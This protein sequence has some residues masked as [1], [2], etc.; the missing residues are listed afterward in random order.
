M[1]IAPKSDNVELTPNRNQPKPATATKTEEEKKPGI[2]MTELYNFIDPAQPYIFAALGMILFF[3][4][5]IISE[6]YNKEQQLLEQ[7]KA[8]ANR[9]EHQKSTSDNREA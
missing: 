3:L 2:I 7:S 5:V 4:L 6:S 9:R 1:G 8:L